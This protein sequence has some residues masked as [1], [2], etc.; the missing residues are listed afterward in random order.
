M[1]CR[2]SVNFEYSGIGQILDQDRI[3]VD[4]T[5][6]QSNLYRFKLDD[7]RIFDLENSYMTP[8]T[9]NDNLKTIGKY[10]NERGKSQKMYINGGDFNV[11]WKSTVKRKK[12]GINSLDQN[13]KEF[14]RIRNY[15]RNG[16]SRT[17]K[18]LIDLIF[19]NSKTR[20]KIMETSILK[21]DHLPFFDHFGVILR[22]DFP[23][24]KPYRDV[25]LARDPFRRPSIPAEL[26]NQ[27]QSEIHPLGMNHSY[28]SFM[29][30]VRGILDRHVP[31]D[32]RHGLYRKRIYDVPYPKEIRHEIYQLERSRV[33]QTGQWNSYKKI[34]TSKTIFKVLR[35]KQARYTS[36][37]FF[38][39]LFLK[40]L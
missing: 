8:D 17:S 19:T 24:S 10:L 7:N 32:G 9:S 1:I 29:L 12:L 16:R 31:V 14:T 27:I 37:P 11:N 2:N 21:T 6:F 35:L 25:W 33:F 13:V 26:M 30:N 22:L 40:F 3:Q 23:K 4:K 34:S 20:P 39:L 18:T 5:V 28:D 15:T 36:M 38:L